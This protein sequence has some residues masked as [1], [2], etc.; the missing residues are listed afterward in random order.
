MLVLL[1]LSLLLFGCGIDDQKNE[2]SHNVYVVDTAKTEPKAEVQNPTKSSSWDKPVPKLYTATRSDE[3]PND[4]GSKLTKVADL[5][6][7]DRSIVF[8]TNNIQARNKNLVAFYDEQDKIIV[9]LDWTIYFSEQYIKTN[10]SDII[11]S[12]I[13]VLY[14]EFGHL[15][16]LKHNEATINV[17]NAASSKFQSYSSIKHLEAA[18]K[19]LRNHDIAIHKPNY[20]SIMALIFEQPYKGNFGSCLKIADADSKNGKIGDEYFYELCQRLPG[21][22][23]KDPM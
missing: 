20:E 18:V 21:I 12:M 6:G 19:Y 22:A 1:F 23:N 2:A 14:H 8:V 3:Y 5:V 13:D 10:P 17:M 15:N 11:I 9:F 4:F 16:G 7:I